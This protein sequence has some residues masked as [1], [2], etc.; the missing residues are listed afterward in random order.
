MKHLT[1]KQLQS[2]FKEY[3]FTGSNE[4]ELAVKIKNINNI[5]SNLRLDIYGNAYFI[6]LQ[7]ALAHDFP[8]LLALM[9]DESFGREMADYLQ[10]YPSTNPSLRYI[11]QN[12]SLWFK[13]KSKYELSELAQLEWA[14]LN[15]FDAAD[16]DH[17]TA[18]TLHAIPH[19]QWHQL[20]FSFHPSISLLTVNSNLFEIWKACLSKN[21]IPEIESIY[22]ESLVI[23]CTDRGPAIQSISPAYQSLFKAL[24]DNKSFGDA[25][26]QLSQLE[27]QQNESNIAAQFLTLAIQYKWIAGIQLK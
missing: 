2:E 20:R 25:C 26:D 6:R 19:E 1:L 9:G 16:A 10:H 14:I 13:K 23:S 12:L 21:N 27:L 15:A 8:V 11:G 24:A 3:L 4:D 22:P 7:E 18:D 17:L 5:N